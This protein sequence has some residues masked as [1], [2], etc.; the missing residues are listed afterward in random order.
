[1]QAH[2]LERAAVRVPLLDPDERKDRRIVDVG[3][4]RV[5]ADEHPLIEAAF[6]IGKRN[7]RASASEARD[8]RRV[9]PAVF[10]RC[11]FD[12]ASLRQRSEKRRG[13]LHHSGGH[14]GGRMR[15]EVSVVVLPEAVRIVDVLG[16]ER[17][18]VAA[19]TRRAALDLG[20]LDEIGRALRQER[21]HFCRHLGAKRPDEL[22]AV[23]KVA[24]RFDPVLVQGRRFEEGL[25]RRRSLQPARLARDV[26]SRGAPSAARFVTATT[27]GE[28]QQDEARGDGRSRA[29]HGALRLSIMA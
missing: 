24:A 20:I 11:R 3:E 13:R 17:R 7:E 29:R 26:R 2:A 14:V 12:G 23:L 21:E 9:G 5:E 27:R 1:M 28:H 16:D 4:R 10:E 18:K 19:K 6:G 8:V 25:P 22:L 15:R